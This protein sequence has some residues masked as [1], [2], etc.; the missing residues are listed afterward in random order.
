SAHRANQALADANRD[1][2]AR[3][4]E[5]SKELIQYTDLLKE[6]LETMDEG[7]VVTDPTGD[8]VLVNS[9]AIRL[10]PQTTPEWSEGANYLKVYTL[11]AAGKSLDLE[12]L[13]NTDNSSVQQRDRKTDDEKWVREIYTPRSGGGYVITL[14]NR[15]QDV[16]RQEHLESLSRDLRLAKDQAE[17]ASLAKS[18]FL[19]NMSHEIRTPM[20]GVLGLTDALLDTPLSASQRDLTEVIHRS[21]EGLISIINDILDFSKLEAGKLVLAGEEFCLETVIEDVIRLMTPAASRKSLKLSFEVAATS[22]PQILGDSGRCRQ[23]I[24][25]LVGNAIKFTDEGFVD[26][27]GTAFIEKDEVH[28]TI[29]VKDTGCG[30]PEDKLEQIFDKFEQVDSSHA[31]RFEGTGLGL[32]IAQ[33]LAHLM[34]GRVYAESTA[35]EGSCFYFEAIFERAHPEELPAPPAPHAPN[36]AREIEAP[37]GSSSDLQQTP[38]A[39]ISHPQPKTSNDK[40]RILVAEDNQVNQFVIRA[41]LSGAEYQLDFA[42]NGEQAVERV[43]ASAPD[44]IL[45]DVSMP[46]MDGYTATQTLR[47]LGFTLPIIGVTAH[48]LAEDEARCLAA[49]MD[50]FLPKPISRDRLIET[51]LGVGPSAQNTTAF[52]A[53]A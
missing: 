34:N 11:C 49:G 15:T 2:E 25:N 26:V 40:L 1:L 20:N 8:I 16:L 35:G 14:I 50:G 24:T 13:M 46:V 53:S 39:P 21:G 3:V 18:Q 45:M 27:K 6:V 44:V 12:F 22:L 5:R 37:V 23:I 52:S 32:A 31:R 19:A 51:L 29:C 10:L 43:K 36:T 48:A 47:E 33:E 28:L 38:R 41:L 30:I 9:K 4:A 7:L 17:A 42:N